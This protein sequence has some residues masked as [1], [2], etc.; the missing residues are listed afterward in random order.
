MVKMKK[1]D[2][3][4]KEGMDTIKKVTEEVFYVKGVERFSVTS[5]HRT[6]ATP[7]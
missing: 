2:I 7:R 6:S 1:G 3:F 5:S 4:T